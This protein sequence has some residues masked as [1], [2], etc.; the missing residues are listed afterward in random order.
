MAQTQ[1]GL[2][3]ALLVLAWSQV[4]SAHLTGI[5]ADGCNGCHRG[6]QAPTVKISADASSIVAGQKVTLT[7]TISATNGPAG[8]FYIPKPASGSFTATAGTKIWPDGGIS[9]SM[10][11]RASGNQV[12]FQ[13]G[14]TPPNQPAMG[15]ADFPVYAISANGDGSSQG[16]GEGQTFLSLAYGCAGTKYF[17]D[18]DGDKYGAIESGWTM[19]C[20][21]PLNYAEQDGDCDDN[22]PTIHPGATEVCDGKD[23]NCNGMIDEGLGSIVLCEDKDGDGHGVIG[24]ATHTGCTPNLKGFGLC[25]GD[26]NDNDPT[27]YPGAMEICDGKDN[28]CNGMIDEGAIPTCGLGWCR[29]YGV[30]CT[31]NICTPGQ[32]RAEICNLFDDDC[33]GVIDN[34]TDLELCGV[35]RA[36]R[37][38][39]CI[40]I[41]DAG[42]PTGGNDVSTATGGSPASVPPG[43][44]TGTGGSG[45]ESTW[46]GDTSNANCAAAAHRPPGGSASATLL[47]LLGHAILQTRSRSRR[48]RTER[49]HRREARR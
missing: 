41:D 20:S 44:G 45:G 8:G 12:T 25:D 24:G 27:V 39:V 38:G 43:T 23:N 36:C 22:D 46:H 21:T 31:S 48:S 1:I 40:P 19:N 11:A 34:G 35:G 2:A 7:V 26:C 9:H 5:E 29:R 13:I 33:D 3:A 15:G 14:W 4:S 42:S 18:R 28:N 16:D 37:Q 10:P 30:S 49:A 32:P 47:A 17:A 6:G